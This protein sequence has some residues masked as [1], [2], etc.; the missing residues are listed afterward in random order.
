MKR[1]EHQKDLYRKLVESE[2]FQKESDA[3]GKLIQDSIWWVSE[4]GSRLTRIAGERTICP[5]H[6][7]GRHERVKCQK[8]LFVSLKKVKRLKKVAPFDC[9]AGKHGTCIPIIQGDRI[10]GYIIICHSKSRIPASVISFFTNFIDTLIRELQKELELAKL[11]RTIRP[12]AIALSTIH[13]IHRIISSTLDLDELLP[14]L[15]RLCL[16][17]F[18]A[19]RCCICLKSQPK[20]LLIVK[21]VSKGEK[22]KRSIFYN[23]SCPRMLHREKV[24]SRG[25]IL[26]RR[27]RLCVPLT[28]ED[29]IGAICIMNKVDRAA[30]DEFDREIL[31]TLSEQAAIAVKNARLYKEQENITLG[32][33]KSIAAILNTRTPGTYRVRESFIRIV[34]A[35]GRELQVRAEDLRSLHYAAILHDAGQIGLPDKLFAKTDRLTGKEYSMIKRHPRKSVSIIKHLSFLKPV[36]P[37]ILHHHE[38]YDG[39]G[40]P[41][42]LKGGEIPLGARIMAVANSFNAMIT[43]R[44]YRKEID[45]KSAIS[46]IKKHSGAQFDADVVRVF[47]KVVRDREIARL[48]RKGL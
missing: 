17:V 43:K 19:K 12:R 16:Q 25:R 33:I 37:I 18:R 45:I 46:E 35:M 10:Y 48:L 23:R 13:T 27:S 11:Y 4:K 1:L 7:K 26:M 24:L 38:N 32:S 21:A 31:L 29:I 34:L 22:A 5:I 41:K 14:K 20:R 9:G 6:M 36:I 2:S 42:G 30:F 47:L 15:A 28:D 40:Y 44:P 8:R 3:L 39:S